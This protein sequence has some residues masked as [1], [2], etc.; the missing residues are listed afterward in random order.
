[1]SKRVL[2]SVF[3]LALLSSE[4]LAQNPSMSLGPPVAQPGWRFAP[5][6]T[7]AFPFGDFGDAYNFGIGF[8]A[9]FGPEFMWGRFGLNPGG[10]FQFLRF[11]ADSD[12]IGDGYALAFAVQPD[13]KASIHLGMAAPYFLFG[14]GFDHFRGGG[15]A[16]D[17]AEANGLE[18]S[19]SGAGFAIGFGCDI[20]F[21]PGLALAL[22][23]EIHP[24]LVEINGGGGGFF[25]I[26]LGATIAF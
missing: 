10:S 2:V 26:N 20:W 14:I 19:G 12:V 17:I 23:L 21:T 15:D 9:R 24:T 18:T 4:A 8:K 7:P 13:V 6:L 22:G 3:G 11:G 16:A 5:A 1:M 25:A